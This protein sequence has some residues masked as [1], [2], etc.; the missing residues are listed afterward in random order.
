[1]I[2][3]RKIIQN[4]IMRRVCKTFYDTNSY[5]YTSLKI[6]MGQFVLII[7]PE[8]A[9]ISYTSNHVRGWFNNHCNNFFYVYLFL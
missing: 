8:G 9:F 3:E 5:S 7:L 2:K 6:A 1:M 4:S